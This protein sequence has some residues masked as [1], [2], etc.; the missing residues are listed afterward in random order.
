MLKFTV[1]GQKLSLIGD[2]HVVAD[3]FD[4][5]T[6]EFRFYSGYDWDLTEKHVFFQLGEGTPYEVVLVDNKFV[7][8]D[9]VNLTTG[10]WS[11]YV[12]GYDI[13][14]ATLVERITTN[15]VSL[16]V[17]AS[18]VP[19]GEPF[20]PSIIPDIL[21]TVDQSTPQRFV[22][23]IPKLAADRVIADD[24]DLVDKKHVADAVATVTADDFNHNDL[25]NKQGG[26]AGEYY[27]TT[28][29]QNAALHAHSNKTAL[30]AVSGTNTGDQDIS[31]AISAH[32]TDAAAHALLARKSET[33]RLLISRKIGAGE[34]VSA[35]TW[36]QDDAGNALS[37]IDAEIRCYFSSNSLANG[38]DAYVY[39]RINGISS[40]YYSTY[41]AT[42]GSYAYLS[43]VRNAFS[44]GIVA[45]K[46]IGNSY[47]MN[48]VSFASDS[49][50][51]PVSSLAYQGI[52]A[53]GTISQIYVS[54]QSGLT[55]LPTG[56]VIEIY[57]RTA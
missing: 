51:I 23:G 54:V 16:T 40:G 21:V 18:G 45:I 17:D 15:K 10:T 7:K 43:R 22:G 25:S 1:E 52:N 38:S 35:I 2:P 42:P 31:G 34:N 13:N 24:N 32:N 27:H 33:M 36:T 14:G 26:A 11:I 47:S 6:G 37:L 3:S 20:P 19:E 29:A 5:L 12:I 53:S 55:Y 48:M 56:T 49:V 4:Y 8:T 41:T 57:G 46:K 28:Q 30:D 39:T 9:H 44:Q 50:S